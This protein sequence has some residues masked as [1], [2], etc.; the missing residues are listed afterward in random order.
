[1][2]KRKAKKVLLSLSTI[3]PEPQYIDIDGESYD[4]LLLDQ[5]GIKQQAR[6]GAMASRAEAI[7]MTA[8]LTDEIV[9]DLIDMYRK[10]VIAVMPELP[11]EVLDKLTLQHLQAIV[12]VFTEA[13]G[14]KIPTDE[15]PEETEK[16]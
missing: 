9:D 13:S 15:T 11:T 14:I 16:E 8:D 3:A 1:M 10:L 6:L 5:L 12:V 2:A 7:K 4:I